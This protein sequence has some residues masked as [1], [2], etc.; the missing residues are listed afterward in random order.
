MRKRGKQPIGWLLR[1]NWLLIVAIIAV[2]L[3]F[4][5]L[6]GLPPEEK[7]ILVEMPYAIAQIFMM[8]SGISKPFD[9]IPL[10][11][12]RLLIAILFLCAS[13]SV[14]RFAAKKCYR[15]LR[16][17]NGHTLIL[18]AGYLGLEIARQSRTRFPDDPIALVDSSDKI[19]EE[20]KKEIPGIFTHQGEVV[21]TQILREF[22][23]HKAR[24]VVIA[25][26]SEV[27]VLAA[28][29][30][31]GDALRGDDSTIQAK[32]ACHIQIH[33]RLIEFLHSFYR[34]QASAAVQPAE[35]TPLLTVSYLINNARR[36][37]IIRCAEQHVFA[38][39]GILIEH[40]IK[41]LNNNVHA[42]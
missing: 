26:E 1:S 29:A 14:F 15:A 37:T 2:V 42:V 18:S 3:A 5:G 33:R 17:P 20:A 19:L 28:A 39:S 12:A 27:D 8:N 6:W 40:I 25:M 22:R 36:V 32:V 41:G 11:L 31:V 21:D 9:S 38:Y 13:C 35:V 23:L 10:I 34:P 30:V 7:P 24:R 4:C 16:K